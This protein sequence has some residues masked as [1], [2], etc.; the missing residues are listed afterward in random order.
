VGQAGEGAGAGGPVSET[1]A[2]YIRIA[3]SEL[4]QR[5]A[6][7]RDLIGRLDLICGELEVVAA[8]LRVADE[9]KAIRIGRKESE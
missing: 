3:P 4:E 2:E 7:L 5:A 9:P 6:E 8:H 1:K